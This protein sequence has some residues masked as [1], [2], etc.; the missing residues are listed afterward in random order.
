MFI[1]ICPHR[2]LSSPTAR[3]EDRKIL[4]GICI[5]ILLNGEKVLPGCL[6]IAPRVPKTVKIAA[7][8]LLLAVPYELVVYGKWGSGLIE[9]GILHKC[10]IGEKRKN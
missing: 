9:Y 3:V 5:E 6:F 8:E 10:V 4:D 2:R 1:F 7:E